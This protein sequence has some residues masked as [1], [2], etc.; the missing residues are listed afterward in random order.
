MIE[1]ISSIQ[2]PP[3]GTAARLK[4]KPKIAPIKM[5]CKNH[6]S[7]RE[8]IPIAKPIKTL[9]ASA[10][11]SIQKPK[12]LPNA[13]HTHIKPAIKPK[14]VVTKTLLNIEQTPFKFYQKIYQKPL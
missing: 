8:E 2:K 14:K 1:A 7:F 10:D 13:P 9:F 4:G 11:K 3:L 5:P 12:P 6:R